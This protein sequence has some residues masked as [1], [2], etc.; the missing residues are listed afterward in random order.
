MS[1]GCPRLPNVPFTAEALDKQLD[2][3][4]RRFFSE[5]RNLQLEAERKTVRLSEILKF[6]TEDF[7][8]R[9]PGLIAYVNRYV[10]EK[11]P[12]G[13]EVEFIDYDWTIRN[14][15]GATR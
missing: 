7:L 10:P 5:P 3:E 8:Q 1:V 13:Y 11:I 15:R 12:E 14:Q 9:S 2:Q 6:Y 4:A